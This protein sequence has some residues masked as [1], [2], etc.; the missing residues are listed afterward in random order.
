MPSC[1]GTDVGSR[2]LTLAT[3]TRTVDC[4]R[5]RFCDEEAHGREPCPPGRC[6]F[7]GEEHPQPPCPDHPWGVAP[8][9]SGRAASPPDLAAEGSRRRQETAAKLAADVERLVATLN[10]A[11]PFGGLAPSEYAH[12]QYLQP[13]LGTLVAERDG[14]KRGGKKNGNGGKK[15]QK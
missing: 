8:L 6:R 13:W 4:W 7:G 12:L 3:P 14:K 11:V 9:A 15:K 2:M 5:E 10:A 1:S